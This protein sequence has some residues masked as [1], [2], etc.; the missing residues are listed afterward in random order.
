MAGDHFV[1]TGR[2]LNRVLPLS[3]PVLFSQEIVVR[4]FPHPISR[5]RLAAALAAITLTTAACG[6]NSNDNA[7]VINLGDD[8]LAPFVDDIQS[9][10]A[11]HSDVNIEFTMFD[12]GTRNFT[13]YAGTPLVINFFARTCPACVAEM[14]EFQ[15]V[16]NTLGDA[17]N[18]V[19]IST[20]HRHEDAQILIE[21]TGVTYDLGWDPA[22]DLFAEFGGIAMPTTVFVSSDGTVI[23]VWSGVLTATDLTAKIQELT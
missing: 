19:G 6:G 4:R 8:G 15:E 1:G 11:V 20:D 18:F 17:V 22:G 2:V 10:A 3:I 12:G 5:Q 9:D 13:S 23:E 14:P 21:E 7:R 16:S